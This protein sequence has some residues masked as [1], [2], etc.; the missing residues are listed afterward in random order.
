MRHAAV[1][2]PPR[3]AARGVKAREEA[4]EFR[5]DLRS[6]WRR[7]LAEGGAVTLCRAPEGYDAFVV[8]DLARALARAG[9]SAPAALVFVARD[10]V[11]AQA[12]IDALAFAAPE[13][14]AL[15]LP[16][17]DCQ[18]YDRVSPN[19]A[20][21][22]E[23]MTA[24][25]RL[26]RT[27]GAIERPRMLVVSV[28][29]LTQRVPPLNYRRRPPPSPPRP[30]TACGMEELALLA[31]RRTAM[32]APAPCATSA[33]MRTRG[34]ILDLY[35]PGAPAPIRLDFFGDTLESIRAFDPETQ[36]STTASC[37]RSISCR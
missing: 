37:A 19:A 5:D 25:A 34:G 3:C 35:P 13:I 36:R 29:A 20:I 21:S 4:D 7:R 32:P 33:I 2:P 14:E 6:L 17:W 27:R 18:P 26:A 11:R 15:Y 24:L 16:S 23:R 9:E 28:N 30:A 22:A 31:R 12:F 8:A 1:R 10:G